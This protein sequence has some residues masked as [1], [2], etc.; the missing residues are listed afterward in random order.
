YTQVNLNAFP[1]TRRV[2]RKEPKSK[3]KPMAHS[4][5]S[6]AHKAALRSCRVKLEESLDVDYILARCLQDDVISQQMKENIE[7]KSTRNQKCSAFLDILLTRGQQ[8]FNNFIAAL[9]V[10]YSFLSVPLE[11]EL[12]VKAL[13]IAKA[14]LVHANEIMVD[15][16][17]A[18]EEEVEIS[19]AS[20]ENIKKLM[21]QLRKTLGMPTSTVSG[22]G[23]IMRSS[24]MNKLSDAHKAALRSS[25][26]DIEESL[27]VQD[28]LPRCIQDGMITQRMKAT[29]LAHPTRHERCS[30]FLDILETRGK[31]AFDIFVSALHDDYHFLKLPLKREL[32]IQ[33]LA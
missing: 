10:N 30:A 21:I 9:S 11:R 22:K 4:P 19:R 6:E 13:S 14:S 33:A 31:K 27:E 3:D 7:A 16:K 20:V 24:S 23:K 29:V 18:D 25:R 26:I 12:R 17:E 1:F 2:R 8:A 28:I 5:L 32:R 15:R